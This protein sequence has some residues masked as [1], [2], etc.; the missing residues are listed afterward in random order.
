MQRTTEATLSRQNMSTF[1]TLYVEGDIDKQIIEDF[2]LNKT[3]NNIRIYRIE[4]DK[5]NICYGSYCRDNSLGAKKQIIEF[6]RHSNNDDTLDKGKYL[7]IID[8]DL[9]YCFNTKENIENLIYTD[10]NSMESYLIDLELLKKIFIDNNINNYEIFENNFSV[11]LNNFIDFNICF[12]T[13]VMHTEEF[14]ED[15]LSFD[16]IP[17]HSIPFVDKKNDYKI[18]IESFKYKVT[19]NSEN[20]YQ[21]YLR[22]Y[23]EYQEVQENCTQRLLEF[24]HGKYLLKYLIGIIKDMFTKLNGTAENQIINSLRDKFIISCKYTQ[25]SLFN[26]INNFSRSSH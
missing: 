26:H 15:T 8:T 10:Y 20:W 13:Q 9:D 23:V 2:L 7:G 17:L 24:L 5:D 19:N 1:K 3:I 12:I 16:E 14:S 11:Y 25:Y 18:N 4:A 21:H 6:I 22:R